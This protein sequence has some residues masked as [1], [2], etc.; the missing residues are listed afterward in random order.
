MGGA[1]SKR[2]GNHNE[3]KL[4][5]ALRAWWGHGEWVRTPSSG[6]WATPQHREAFRACGD[7]M[8][9]AEDFPFCVEAKKREKW[10]MDQLIHNEACQVL[11]WWK[12][13]KDETPPGLIPLLIFA[14]NMVPQAVM[15]DDLQLYAHCAELAPWH[16]LTHF[17][18]R[19]GKRDLVITSLESFFTIN[20]NIFGRKLAMSEP[21]RPKPSDRPNVPEPVIP[22]CSTCKKPMTS[23]T[24]TD[25]NLKK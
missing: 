4:A 11:D 16:N 3:R 23:C 14:R 8:T 13:T 20:P 9:T 10:F 6:G 25:N 21:N 22:T 18:F 15:F 12:Q 5:A 19:L 7:I 1:M 2:K 17:L 24:C